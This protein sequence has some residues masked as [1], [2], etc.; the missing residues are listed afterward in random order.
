MCLININ[1]LWANS[2]FLINSNFWFAEWIICN[3]WMTRVFDGLLHE[4]DFLFVSFLLG[5]ALSTI[6]PSCWATFCVTIYHKAFDSIIKVESYSM[7]IYVPITTYTHIYFT[8][9][10]I[11]I[12]ICSVFVFLYFLED[13]IIASLGTPSSKGVAVTIV[14]LTAI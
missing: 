6:F 13:M 5:L 1:K 9:L 12:M 11:A 14:W 8:F 4:T 7:L 3:S 10:Q 2:F